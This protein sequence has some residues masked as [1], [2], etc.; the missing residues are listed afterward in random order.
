[1]KID[2]AM[3]ATPDIHGYAKYSIALNADYALRHG[4]GFHVLTMPSKKRSATWGKIDVAK[5]L[6]PSCD[7]LFIIDADAVIVDVD[8]PLEDFTAT[9]GELLICENGPNGGR[10]LNC[11]AMFLKNTLAMNRFLDTWY[12]AGEKYA[13]KHFH[14]QDALNDL[15]EGGTDIKIVPFSYDSF[16]SHFLDYK[17]PSWRERF[18][19]HVMQH[20]TEQRAEIFRRI[21]EM[22]EGTRAVGPLHD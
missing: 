3:V 13:L 21:Y 8:K 4:Y 10:L 12:Q 14:E 11:G 16:N 9:E 15:F 6:L 22:R 18:V 5:L 1:M 20:S 19:L 7:W 17:K 2:I